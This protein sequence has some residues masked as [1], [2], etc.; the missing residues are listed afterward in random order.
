MSKIVVAL[1]AGGTSSERDV[2]LA[3]G[4]QIFAALDKDKYTVLRYDP[5]DDISRLVQ[6]ADRVDTAF[7]NLHGR[8]GEDGSVQGLLDLLGIPYQCSGVLGSALAT[9][10]LASKRIYEQ[11]GLPVPPYSVIRKREKTGPEDWR[12]H[13]AFTGEPV[14][15]KPVSGGS[16]IGMSIVTNKSD[17]KQAVE[18]AWAYDDMVLLEAYIDGVELTGGVIGNDAITPLPVVE[19]IPGDKF[20]FFDY[21][22]KYTPGATREVCPAEIDQKLAEKVQAYACRAHKALFCKGCSRT[23]MIARGEDV[24]VLETNTIPGMVSTSLLPLAAKAA[25]LSF[26][27]LLDRLIALSLEKPAGTI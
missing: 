26:S 8:Y 6:D 20:Q 14:V 10:K 7:V 3:G 13:P 19:I 23:D 25:G 4:D 1:I 16:S 2:S 24:F 21:E 27:A 22:A 5:R 18:A 15:I 17:L 12:A 9:N 11:A